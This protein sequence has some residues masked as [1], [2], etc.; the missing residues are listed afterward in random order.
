V[1]RVRVLEDLMNARVA[2]PQFASLK[3]CAVV[4]TFPELLLSMGLKT[5]PLLAVWLVSTASIVITPVAQSFR[6]LSAFAKV[7]DKSWEVCWTLH[8]PAAQIPSAAYGRLPG[9]LG[10]PKMGTLTAPAI[11]TKC[12]ANVQMMRGP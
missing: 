1:S 9:S 10:S 7:S 3:A 12:A 8:T 5:I 2:G 11:V 6:D 4:N